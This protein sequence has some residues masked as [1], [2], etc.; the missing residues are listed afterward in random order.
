MRK[1]LVWTVLIV[2]TLFFTKYA[3]ELS[4]DVT[5]KGATFSLMRQKVVSCGNGE[6]TLVGPNGPTHLEIDDSWPP[7]SQF[8]Q[9]TEYDLW[10]AR[11]GRTVYISS[12]KTPWWRQQL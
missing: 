2:A 9:N 7:C 12:E 6:I 11:G 1:I 8:A 5:P 4:Q 10:L 3:N